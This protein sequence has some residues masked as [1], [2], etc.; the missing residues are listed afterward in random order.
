MQ[1]T[2]VF[3]DVIILQ[4]L[5]VWRTLEVPDWSLM[6][7]PHV[8]FDKQ[9]IL[10]MC[11]KFQHCRLKIKVQRTLVFVDVI[12]LQVLEVWMTLEVP[13]WSLMPGPHLDFNQQGILGRCAKFLYYML[14][15]RVQRTPV[16]VNI[17]IS[18]FWRF[19]GLWRF[20]IGV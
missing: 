4:V 1:R 11:A 5:E 9:L 16:S 14:K 18:R 13:D 8:D 2:L 7:G 17:I 20:L 10:A 3:E 15:T 12:I 6:T 19:G